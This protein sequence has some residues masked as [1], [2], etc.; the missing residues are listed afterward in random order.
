MW[1]AQSNRCSL[2]LSNQFVL[3]DFFGIGANDLFHFSLRLAFFRKSMISMDLILKCGRQQIKM[4][5]RVELDESQKWWNRNS[6][7]TKF[8]NIKLKRLRFCKWKTWYP[9]CQPSHWINYICDFDFELGWIMYKKVLHPIFNSINNFILFRWAKPIH[10][11]S[12]YFRI[13]ITKRF[14]QT[15]SRWNTINNENSSQRTV[16][17]GIKPESKSKSEYYDERI[18]MML[19]ISTMI[20]NKSMSNRYWYWE[21]CLLLHYRPVNSLFWNAHCAVRFNL[22]SGF[23]MALKLSVQIYRE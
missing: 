3:N 13:R 22:Y 5:F 12:L 11:Q 16:M 4:S 14:G 17:L 20:I 1:F 19:I 2:F 21:K 7:P 18:N 23:D 10:G 15:N 9:C 8:K 6:L